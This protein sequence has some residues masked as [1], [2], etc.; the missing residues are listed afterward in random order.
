MAISRLTLLQP[1]MTLSGP[2]YLEKWLLVLSLK[3][4]KKSVDDTNPLQR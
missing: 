3:N 4:L 2:A 1:L